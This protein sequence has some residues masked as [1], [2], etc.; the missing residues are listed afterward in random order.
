[1]SEHTKER[2]NYLK[3]Q[4][5]R[6]MIRAGIL[7]CL[8][9]GGSFLLGSGTKNEM[10]GYVAMLLSGVVF[11]LFTVWFMQ[12]TVQNITDSLTYMEQKFENFSKGDLSSEIEKSAVLA[13]DFQKLAEYAEIIRQNAE[14]R[15]KESN[16]KIAALSGSIEGLQEQMDELKRRMAE[17]SA[18]AEEIV[19]SMERIT[20]ASDQLN[21]FTKEMQASAEHTTSRMEQSEE[22]VNAVSMRADGIREEALKRKQIVLHSQLEMKDS[23][24]R[25][26][27][28]VQAVEEVSNLAD[29]VM[30]IT[31]KTNMLSL[32]ASI[33]AAKAGQAGNGF[34][35]VADEI[36]KLA[37]ESK[38]SVE[39]IQWIAGE[40]HFAIES[41]KEDSKRLLHF[42]DSKVVSDFD[43]FLDMADVYGN[44]AEHM[45]NLLSE[46]EEICIELSFSAE[47]ISKSAEQIG[48]ASESS[49]ANIQN[50]KN[51]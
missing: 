4:L 3:I 46:L 7:L 6:Y 18:S 44:D 8:L 14:G 50:L 13:E 24:E 21:R 10:I 2:R 43:F 20:S 37:D 15:R 12:K 34:S 51:L 26:L 28:A 11:F 16:Q 31:E 9:S 38:K 41:L 17:A 27:K 23:F 39:N 45:K 49:F 48:Q 29:A 33:E 30:E 25:S 47:G 42:V 19:D 36:R 22:Q 32:N 5:G 1:M 40:A 35:V